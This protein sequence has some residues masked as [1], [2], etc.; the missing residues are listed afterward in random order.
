MI[1]PLPEKLIRDFAQKVEKLYVVEELDS[2]IEDH[3]RALGVVPDRGKELSPASWASFL[4][5]SC[6]GRLAYPRRKLP[7]YGEPFP[8]DP[9]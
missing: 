7:N 5:E 6:A 9:R 4:R 8:A 1:Y 2:C 3:V